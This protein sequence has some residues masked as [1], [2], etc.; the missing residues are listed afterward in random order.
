MGGK[1]LK[2]AT[3]VCWKGSDVPRYREFALGG[4]RTQTEECQKN[5]RFKGFGAH[6]ASCF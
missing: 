4:L 5:P 3:F 1:S 6:A 2:A